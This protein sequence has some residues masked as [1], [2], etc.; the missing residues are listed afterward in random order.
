MSLADLPNSFPKLHELHD[1]VNAKMSAF[2]DASHDYEHVR[3][4]LR[5]ASVITAAEN[6]EQAF[7]QD[8]LLSIYLTALLHDMFDHKCIKDLTLE[9]IKAQQRTTLS[10]LLEERG[11]GHLADRVCNAIE[12]ISYSAEMRE[13]F[14][15][16]SWE[17][18]IAQDSDRL[19]AIGA[20][21]IARVFSFGG[22]SR[23]PFYYQASQIDNEESFRAM[24][25]KCSIGHFPDKLLKLSKLMK[26]NTGRS[27]AA[28]RHAVLEQ[29]LLAFR[30]EAVGFVPS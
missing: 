7:D 13:G 8:T 21:G 30:S 5:N 19:D 15:T 28:E 10:G 6:V 20:V 17:A 26:T 16:D 29:F 23:R 22:L 3:R 11:L 25:S 14:V 1:L 4:V 9:E 27:L 18:K 2:Q 24:D 12:K